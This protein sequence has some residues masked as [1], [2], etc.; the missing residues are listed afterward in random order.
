M[1]FSRHY[2]FVRRVVSDVFPEDFQIRLGKS[3]RNNKIIVSSVIK[4]CNHH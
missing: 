1:V 4:F 2:A 3:F